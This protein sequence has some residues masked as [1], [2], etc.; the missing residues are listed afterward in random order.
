MLEVIHF[1]NISPDIFTIDIGFFS[2][3]LKWYALAYI[4]GLLLAW[5]ACDKT[6]LVPVRDLI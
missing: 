6:N 1:P 4:V 5:R 2:F 3:S